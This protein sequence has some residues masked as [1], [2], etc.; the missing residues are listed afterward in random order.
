[1]KLIDAINEFANW[2]SIQ[3]QSITVKGN[4]QELRIFWLFAHAQNV[5]DVTLDTI[6][7]YIRSV[8]E[9]G[10]SHNNTINRCVSL[11]VFFRYCRKRG[12]TTL[13]EMLIPIPDR[14]PKRPRVA[15][16][17]H[18]RILVASLSGSDPITVRNKAMVTMLWD[19]GVRRGEL[20]DLDC[21]DLDVAHRRAIIR[22]AKKRGNNALR[23]VYWT[24]P[25]NDNLKAWLKT[26]AKISAKDD[27]LWLRIGRGVG[28]RMDK[29]GFPHLL[30]SLCEKAGVPWMNP[31]SFR[32]ALGRD[33]AS[34]GVNNSVI[35]NIFGHADMNSSR[36]YTELYG[37]Q[38]QE[39]YHKVRG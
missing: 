21:S 11:R 12:Y 30:R 36:V 13:D 15:N 20:C 7:D 26:R 3:R 38:L 4:I 22:S 9:C 34:K 29:S 37:D 31:H 5:S 6:I 35:S 17:E 10:Y 33:L 39:V 24:T 25:T 8:R 28:Q 18:Y 1:M 23:Q 27:A 2:R 16:E 14:E 19:T 32:H